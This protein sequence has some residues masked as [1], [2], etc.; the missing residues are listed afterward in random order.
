MGVIDLRGTTAIPLDT[1]WFSDSEGIEGRCSASMKD[2]KSG[3][4]P[5]GREP[6]HAKNSSAPMGL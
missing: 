2:T 6:I 3:H 4:L 1:R 5:I